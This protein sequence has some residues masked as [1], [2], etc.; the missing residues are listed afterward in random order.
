MHK[1]F[2][3]LDTVPHV[4]TAL[5]IRDPALIHVVGRADVPNPNWLVPGFPSAGQQAFGDQLLADHLF[6][7]IPSAVSTYSWNLLFDA[8]RATAGYQLVSQEPFAL[9]MR[10]HPPS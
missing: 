3:T 7:A 10:L 6:V 8:Q 4:L 1:G 9:D 5:Q 2:K